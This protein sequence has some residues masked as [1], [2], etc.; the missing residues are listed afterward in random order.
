MFI[1]YLLLSISL[2]IDSFGIGTTYGL[3]G[4]KLSIIAKIILF[5]ISFF[6]I[7]ISMNFGNMLQNI[8]P[9]YLVKTIGVGL[10]LFIGIW[11][12]YQTLKK[13]ENFKNEKNIF[14]TNE[15]K[16]YNFFIK[17]LGIT[18]KIIRNPISSDFD[19]SKTIDW[20]EALYL[21]VTISIDSICAGIGSSMLGFNSALLPFLVACFSLFFILIGIKLGHKLAKCLN[22]P[23]KLWNVLSRMCF[24]YFRYY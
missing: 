24:N 2:S 16:I 13:E 3:K 20:K 22:I 19:N 9:F 4:T 15:Q 7:N 1:N 18:I 6:F 17:S 11:I 12:I 14:L 10:F 8:L 5:C 23:S 21:G